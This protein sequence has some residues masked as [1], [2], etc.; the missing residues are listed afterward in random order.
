[1]RQLNDQ[2][3]FAVGIATIVAA[4]VLTSSPARSETIAGDRI[5]IIDGDTVALPPIGGGR[6]ERIRLLDIDAPETHR[7]RCAVEQ[8][9]ARAA[10][11]KL[12]HLRRFL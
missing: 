10:A 11:D 5:V 1:M 4:A 3:L 9:A 8:L 7:P 2:I 12:A 6:G